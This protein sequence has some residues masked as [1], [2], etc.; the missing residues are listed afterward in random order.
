MALCKLLN[1]LGAGCAV[2]H[3]FEGCIVKSSEECSHSKQRAMRSAK[4]ERPRRDSPR[5]PRVL[6]LHKQWA[7]Y[8]KCMTMCPP[9]YY[10]NAFMTTPE[11]GHIYLYIYIQT[12]NM[13]KI[14]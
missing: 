9:G 1:N 7:K 10:H 13:F 12:S 3:C 8:T 2:T 6:K 5:N 4:S 11:L 14:I